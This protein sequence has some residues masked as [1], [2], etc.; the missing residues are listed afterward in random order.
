MT[1]ARLSGRIEIAAAPAVVAAAL[2]DPAMLR[3]MIPGCAE[4]SPAGPD[5]WSARIE[6]AAGPVTLRLVA[7]IALQ[8]LPD[9]AGY[10]LT[11]QGKSLIAGSVSLHLAL[12]LRDTD[13]STVLE[14]DG[15]LRAEGMAG[16][17]L[18]GNEA[19][20][21]ARSDQLF[22][23]LREHVEAAARA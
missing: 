1:E 11:A 5:A 9:E 14:H 19:R 6:K 16:R 8:T 15:T 17:L 23:S 12:A 21:A 20:V 10:V 3:Q 22:S 18:Q 13:G 7:R 2:H 4:I